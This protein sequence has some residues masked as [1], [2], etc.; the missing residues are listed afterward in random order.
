M[1]T[2]CR[3][4][5]EFSYAEQVNTARRLLDGLIVYRAELGEMGRELEY[6][7]RLRDIQATLDVPYSR[8]VH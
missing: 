2:Y 6:L 8:R 3:N 7:L 4:Y 5:E 1:Q